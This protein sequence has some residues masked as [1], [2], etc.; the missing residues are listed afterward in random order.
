MSQSVNPP[1][2]VREISNTKRRVFDLER[3][4]QRRERDEGCC[5]ETQIFATPGGVTVSSLGGSN[6]YRTAP[7]TFIVESDWQ[8]VHIVGQITY[9]VEG[10]EPPS[11]LRGTASILA[12]DG[13]QIFM[14]TA[15]YAIDIRTVGT[16][17]GA[18]AYA[19]LTVST[20]EDFPSGYWQVY[21]QGDAEVGELAGLG[22]GTV[23]AWMPA[24]SIFGGSLTAT[25]GQKMDVQELWSIGGG[26]T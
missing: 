3:R 18:S 11:L 6:M 1:R 7:A 17:D 21:I 26:S 4:L 20:T 15:S 5:G 9:G 14:F 8:R 23:V 19:T 25:F 10:G 2:A 12:T 16:P 24:P 13:A 22:L